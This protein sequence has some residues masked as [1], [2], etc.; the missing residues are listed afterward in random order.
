M[1][2]VVN[3]CSEFCRCG[4]YVRNRYFTIKLAANAPNLQMSQMAETGAEDQKLRIE[5]MR[6]ANQVRKEMLLVV[7]LH[8][9]RC[10]RRS[11]TGKKLPEK[12]IIYRFGKQSLSIRQML[13]CMHKWIKPKCKISILMLI[14]IRIYIWRMKR[15]F[16]IV[17]VPK[18]AHFLPC[19][20]FGFISSSS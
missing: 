18:N 8:Q 7:S 19:S 6:T 11:S 5:P 20:I 12:S 15:Y 17:V 16:C 9:R 2:F 4:C 14:T 10:L 13:E 1:Y 3:F